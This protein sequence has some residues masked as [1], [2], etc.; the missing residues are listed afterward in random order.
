[1]DP[2][3]YFGGYQ[4]FE[5]A[6][7]VIGGLLLIV[8]LAAL[9]L[10]ILFYILTAAGMYSIAKRRGILH[11]WLAWIPVA[12]AW[13]LGS[14]SDQYQYVVKGKVKNRRTVLLSLSI[15]A[16]VISVVLCLLT[17]ETVELSSL[18][19]AAGI[20]G[21]SI[22]LMLASVVITAVYA[23]FRYLALFDLYTSCRADSG[24][25][26]LVV[27]M[28]FSIT[29]PFLIFACRKREDGMPPRK[30]NYQPNPEY[31]QPTQDYNPQQPQDTWD[32]NP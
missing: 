6:L 17:G 28:L 16:V 12:N 5:T 32:Q 27:S 19:A 22:L 26:Y 23:V 21:I 10:G 3:Y 18:A 2:Y 20:G 7:A 4:E 9:F 1:M 25:V 13:L 15:A 14:I 30:V 31:S 24:V 29:E 8:L 11:P